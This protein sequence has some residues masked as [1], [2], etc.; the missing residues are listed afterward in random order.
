[1]FNKNFAMFQILKTLVLLLITGMAFG[2][3]PIV[4]LK[5]K[6]PRPAVKDVAWNKPFDVNST[7]KAEELFGKEAAKG[8]GKEVDFTKQYL[9]VF[10]W[11]GSGGDKLNFT[12]AESN[13]EHFS[14]SMKRGLTRDLRQ[15]MQVYVLRSNVTWKIMDQ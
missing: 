8:I 13:P 2:Q 14:F 5:F 7:E 1:M 4:A 12:V 10:L 11:Q 6:P 9:L 3:D 15:H